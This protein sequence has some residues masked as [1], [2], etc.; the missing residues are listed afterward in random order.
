MNSRIFSPGRVLHRRI[1]LTVPIIALTAA[2]GNADRE[3]GLTGENPVES[4]KYSTSGSDPLS[5]VSLSV[6]SKGR[7]TSI[8]QIQFDPPI[9]G[10]RQVDPVAFRTLATEL[11]ALRVPPGIKQ[12]STC[13]AP[14]HHAPNISIVWGY[15]D[16]R[17]GQ[18]A[19]FLNCKD[20]VSARF[21][22]AA[23]AL[24]RE[25]DDNPIE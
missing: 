8:T 1:W 11:R 13:D 24:K 5:D 12:E 20:G 10:H 4:I 7:L 9:I 18:L 2:C 22:E 17:E 15:R 16:G 23:E 6:D 14:S 3:A 25:F 19:S 21:N